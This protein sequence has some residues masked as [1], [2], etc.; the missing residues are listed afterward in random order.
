MPIPAIIVHG[1]AGT[2]EDERRPRCLAGVERA[3]R[4]GWEALARGGSAVDAVEAAVRD[5]EDDPE[6]NA[7]YGA[8][9]NRL[10]TVEVDACVMDGELRVGAVAAVPWL[11]HPVTLARRVLEAG[12]HALL[13]AG[14]ALLYARE[15]EIHPDPPESMI[16]PRSKKRWEAERDRRAAEAAK[17]SGAENSATKNSAEKISNE[18]NS[19]GK[20]SG[21][22]GDTVGACAVDAQGRVAAATST[23]GTPWKRPGRVGDSPLAGC[24][25]YAD[26]RAGAASATGHGESIIRVVMTRAA[27]DR[28][29][30]GATPD[31]AARVAVAELVERTGGEGG[32]ILVGLDGAVGHYTS[33]PRMPWA[34]VAGGRASSGVEPE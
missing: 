17:N 22:V 6:F 20:N 2:V 14:G 13:V 4:A 25:N 5:M 21:G 1:G 15:F 3:A 33:T 12:E 10:G 9:L 30:A 23:G 28:L 29:R 7:G 32:I 11:R 34:A 27:V 19:T 8:V 16:A 24:G 31:E 18:K 26:A